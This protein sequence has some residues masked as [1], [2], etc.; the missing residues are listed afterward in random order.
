MIFPL[1]DGTSARVVNIY[2][3][4]ERKLGS[5][6]RE[7]FQT[8]TVDNG[9]ENSDFDGMETSC[10]DGKRTQVYYCHPYHAAE[11][12]SNENQNKQIR[13]RIPKGTPIANY[14]PEQ[15]AAV[16][17]WINTN[18]RKIH[19]W[20]TAEQV[21]RRDLTAMGLNADDVIT[22]LCSQIIYN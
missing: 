9:S 5:A 10:F 22:K 3:E 8:V 19:Q 13:R 6:F 7:I 11:R 12:G 17:D 18:P 2:N 14:T 4:L 20:D 16:Q 15:I 1:L 21:F